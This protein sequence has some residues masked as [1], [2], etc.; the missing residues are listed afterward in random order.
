MFNFSEFC[1]EKECEHY[2]EWNIQ[3]GA[4]GMIRCCNLVGMSFYVTTYPSDCIHIDEIQAKE[5]HEKEKHDTWEKISKPPRTKLQELI[6]RI[7]RA[8]KS[9]KL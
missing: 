1:K 6:A 9:T 3:A 8:D 7:A 5:K 2:R 4:G